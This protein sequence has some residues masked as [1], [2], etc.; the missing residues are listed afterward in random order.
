[1]TRAISIVKIVAIALQT[2][3]CSTWKPLVRADEAHEEDKQSSVRDQVLAKLQEGMRVKIRVR[4]GTAAPI[5]GASVECVVEEIGEMALTVT[6]ITF[7]V[8]STER[9]PFSLQFVDIIGIEFLDTHDL[10]VW[11]GGVAVGAILAYFVMA[12][13]LSGIEL[14]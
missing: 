2:V 5:K 8:R 4:E 3:G 6:P 9:K 13:A 12:L 10:D 11:V 1:M 14:D 7:Y